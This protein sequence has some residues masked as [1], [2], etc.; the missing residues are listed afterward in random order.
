M[1]GQKVKSNSLSRRLVWSFSGFVLFAIL[2]V[3]AWMAWWAQRQ[4]LAELRELTATNVEFITE[5]RLPRSRDLAKRLAH[6]LDLGVGFR[7]DGQGAGDWP[8]ELTGVIE[9]LARRGEPAAA[10]SGGVEVGVAPF[11][12]EGASL[13][14][15]REKRPAWA[16]FAGSVAAPAILFTLVCAA[17]ALWTGRRIVQPIERLANWLP[18]LDVEP[19]REIPHLAEEITGR[20]DEIGEL[21]RSLERT[22]ERLR[23]EQALRRQSERMATLGRIATSLAHEIKN[24]AAAIALHADLLARKVDADNAESVALIR[25]EVE[26][27]TDLINQWLFVARSRPA[28]KEPHDLAA[29]LEN[30]RR[31]LEPVLD[32][33]RADLVLEMAAD[34]PP[35]R[36]SADAPRI[37]QAFRNLI[38]NAAQAMPGGGQIRV[39]AGAENGCA[40]VRIEDEGPGFSPAALERFGE[41]FFSEREGGMGIGLTLAR[42]VVQAHGGSLEPGRGRSGACVTCRLP[43]D[44]S[45]DP[46]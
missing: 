1:G 27:I 36:I 31:R 16:G 19:E 10:R 12:G 45:E 3:A 39:A 8:D 30:V 38:L 26:R 41:P 43:L 18:N 7:F 4:S 13:I 21:A 37:E 44:R 11:A 46:S 29:L 17:L 33:C 32:H 6:I 40:V 15:V 14:L 24:P 25:E 28:R 22:T 35:L 42:E 9:Q 23:R 5:L 20:R 2:A 34:S